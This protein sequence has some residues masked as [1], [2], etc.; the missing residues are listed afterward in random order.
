MSPEKNRCMLETAYRGYFCMA[1]KDGIRLKAPSPDELEKVTDDELEA[2][3]RI[4]KE[5]LRTPHS[6]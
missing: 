1:E 5:V 2:Y 3:L 6:T 4:F